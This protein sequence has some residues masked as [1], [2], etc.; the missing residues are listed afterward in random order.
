MLHVYTSKDLSEDRLSVEHRRARLGVIGNPIAHSCSP[1][2]QQAAL[3]ALGLPH[4][5]IRL[6]ADRTPGAFP[7]MVALLAQR[8][9][10]GANVTIPFKK[11]ACELAR[12]SDGIDEL[13]A[14]CGAS[15]TLVRTEGG[16]RAF[17]TDG[18]GFEQAVAEHCGRP[19]S[20]L[21]TLIL[22]ACGGAGSAL[23][24]QCTLSACPS[25]TLVNRPRPEL[26]ELAARLA[27]HAA[28]SGTQ[29][30]TAAIG[31]EALPAALAEAEL[32]V[33]ATPL[34]LKDGDPLPLD[35]ALLHPG[36]LVCDIVPR[37]TP[38]QA[39]ASERG[40][41]A[42]DGMGMLLWQ[43]ACAF[44]HWFG[45]LPPIDTMRAALANLH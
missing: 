36:Q 11:E 43:G 21:K 15:N 25:L 13:S 27:P 10:L 8:G 37:A 26:A 42:M 4:L 18:P 19:L 28:C 38:L 41:R 32:I 3:D 31:S 6:L 24:A 39:A 23:A 22:G 20:S 30:A 2:M 40:C 17:N 12:R 7:A 33:N 14:L 34:G 45:V 44:R 16:W 9:F 1:P 35:P 29:L 5:Y